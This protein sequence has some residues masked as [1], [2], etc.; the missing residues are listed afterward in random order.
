MVADNPRVNVFEP[1][2]IAPVV[3]FNS[4]SMSTLPVR[5]IP[6]TLSTSTIFRVFEPVKLP[7]MVWVTF[8]ENLIDASVPV[9]A[10]KLPPV[11]IKSPLISISLS[12]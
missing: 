9:A 12:S 5:V 2:V 6:F 11:L 3:R 1:V 8:D 7:L 4:A 10:S